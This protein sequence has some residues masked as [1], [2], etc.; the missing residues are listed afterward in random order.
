M[1]TI[2]AANIKKVHYLRKKKFIDGFLKARRIIKISKG[3]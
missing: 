1:V 3:R 2:F